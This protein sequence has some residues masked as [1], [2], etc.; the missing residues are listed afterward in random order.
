MLRLHCEG[1][2][3][4]REYKVG[5][6]NLARIKSWEAQ[7]HFVKFLTSSLWLAEKLEKVRRSSLQDDKDA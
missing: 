4:N 7:C 6:A 5:N 1:I 3:A 2:S